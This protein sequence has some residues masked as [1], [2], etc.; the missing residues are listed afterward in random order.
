MSRSRNI[1]EVIKQILENVPSDSLWDALREGLS[2]ISSKSAYKP[3]E[4]IG[5]CWSSLGTLLINHLEESDEEW[6]QA[7]SEIMQG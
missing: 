1:Q 2:E 7:I 6:K 3:P 5:E 4:Q